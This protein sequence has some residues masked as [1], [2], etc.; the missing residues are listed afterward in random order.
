MTW[1][2]NV[3][4]PFLLTSLLLPCI[5]QRVV[6]V[7]SISAASSIDFANLQ[8]VGAGLR[9]LLRWLLRCTPVAAAACPPP[10]HRPA[11]SWAHKRSAAA[12]PPAHPSAHANTARMVHQ[13][14]G[15]SAHGAYSLSKLADIV[16]SHALAERL[17]AAGSPLTSNCLDPGDPTCNPGSWV[18]RTCSVVAQHVRIGRTGATICSREACSAVQ[19]SLGLLGVRCGMCDCQPCWARHHTAAGTVNTK[20]LFAGWGPIGMRVQVGWLPRSS[21]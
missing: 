6:T 17:R 2:V 14:R 9:R 19:G 5:S 12:A 18:F 3:A 16:F 10:S 21:R 4:A 7:A 11:G 13:E 1:A 8:Q 15:Y 20:M